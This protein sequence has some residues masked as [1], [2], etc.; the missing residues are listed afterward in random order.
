[1]NKYWLILIL[2]VLLIPSIQAGNFSSN[3]AYQWLISKSNVDSSYNSDI[4][5]SA[6]ATLALSEAGL[7]S[8]A[9]KSFSWLKTK[10]SSQYCFPINGCKTKD[11]A[12]GLWVF[13]NFDEDTDNIE[14]WLDNAQT[15][16]ITTGNWWLEIATT[17]SGTCVLSYQ[18]LGST[19][20]F[21]VSVVRGFFPG[22]GNT[23]FLD[24]NSCL[25]Q[26][27]TTKNPFLKLDV[28]CDALGGSII[29]AL[30]YN[31]GNSYYIIDEGYTSKT[32]LHINNGCFGQVANGPCNVEATLYINWILSQINSQIN[33]IPFL[34]DNYDKT[35]PRHA[36]LLYLITKKDSYVNDL[37]SLQKTDG[38]FSRSVY[39]TSLAI[40]ALNKAGSSTEVEK[41]I[42]WLKS[43][44]LFD[45]SWNDNI[46]DTAITLYAAF[47]EQEPEQPSC[48]DGVVNQ[49][50]ENCDKTDLQGKTCQSFGFTGGTLNCT[51]SCTFDKSKCTGGNKVCGNGIVEKPNAENVY[52]Q[53]DTDNLD[54]QS[55]ITRDAYSGGTLKCNSNNCMFDYSLCTGHEPKCSDGVVNQLSENCDKTDLQGKT[56]QS[57]GFTSG[58][59]K[60]T[61]SCEFDKSKC[62]GGNV[63]SCT[64]SIC[65]GDEDCVFNKSKKVDCGGSCPLSCEEIE[66]EKDSDCESGYICEAYLCIKK[67]VTEKCTSDSDCDYGKTCVDGECVVKKQITEK[68]TSDSDCIMGEEECINGECVSKITKECTSDSD[69]PFDY[70][71]SNGY[72]TP[73]GAEKCTSDSDCKSGYECKNG[74]CII[75]SVTECTLDS[76][77]TKYGSGL[78]CKEGVCTTKKGI[79]TLWIIILLIILI[80]L[81]TGGYFLYQKYYKKQGPSAR[82]PE[83]RPFTSILQPKTTQTKTSISYKKE[84]TI[85]SKIEEELDKSLKEAK[86]LLGKK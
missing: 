17:N 84:P 7:S 49:L 29:T 70:I 45:G 35:N 9:E 63:S 8:Q 26:G 50:S 20:T 47:K 32:T 79:S 51:S 22:C 52:E 48:S 66:C 60:C 67:S 55:C 19:K 65:N 15:S 25:E 69:C 68:C 14:K 18:K 37:K 3:K 56:C 4:P 58:T 16:S 36:S 1:M 54:G 10:N 13:S 53:C 57:F 31:T 33:N 72:C 71:C 39:D 76:D 23:T 27:L 12:F 77:C 61:S 82:R 38:S 41:A 42:E 11:T 24:L 6:F 43:K 85:K 5:T 80:L 83:F 2:L 46:M 75:K 86:K 30:I 73:K 21:N 40:I 59:L 44:Q 28:N 62:T 78:V 64:D 74:S 81:G 34:E